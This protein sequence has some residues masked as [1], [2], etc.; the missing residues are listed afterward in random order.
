M[1]PCLDTKICCG[2]GDNVTSCCANGDGFAWDNATFLGRDA[3]VTT[4]TATSTITQLATAT[5]TQQTPTS[6]SGANNCYKQSLALRAGLGVPLGLV[7]L[8]AA[9]LGYRLF[10]LKYTRR[11][12]TE[13]GQNT[14]TVVRR[15]GRA[16]PAELGGH[17]VTELPGAGISG[18]M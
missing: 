4:S 9:L 3:A 18:P 5:A 12:Y 1:S 10:N 17:V 15:T 7:L 8:S 6:A 2:D 16:I 11:D 13:R 14:T